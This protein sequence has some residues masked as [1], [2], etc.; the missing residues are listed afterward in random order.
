M[1]IKFNYDYIQGQICLVPKSQKLYALFVERGMP[2][3]QVL[4][5]ILT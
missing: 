5:F 2:L 4:Y 3:L 1:T